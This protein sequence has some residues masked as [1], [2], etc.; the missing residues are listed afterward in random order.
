MERYIESPVRIASS[1]S[2]SAEVESDI[3]WSS[4]SSTEVRTLVVV[5]PPEGVP[6]DVE[7]LRALPV[8]GESTG[9]LA[10]VNPQHPYKESCKSSD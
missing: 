8:V 1:T 4:R 5:G 9:A 3:E 10:R 2:Q 7:P 6:R